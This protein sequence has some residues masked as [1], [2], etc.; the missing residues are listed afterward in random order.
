MELKDGINLKWI[1]RI[2]ITCPLIL[3]WEVLTLLHGPLRLFFVPCYFVIL[4]VE[5]DCDV[6]MRILCIKCQ[7]HSS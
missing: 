1:H 6:F 3:G 2:H 7:K 4:S 5:F